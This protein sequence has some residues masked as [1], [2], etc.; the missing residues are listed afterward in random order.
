MGHLG[1]DIKLTCMVFSVRGGGNIVRILRCGILFFAIFS[2]AAAG[3]SNGPATASPK[4]TV[5]GAARTIPAIKCVDHETAAACKSF[6]QL[7]DA[8]DKRL[9]EAVWGEQGHNNKHA[10]YVCFRP[11]EDAFN[12]IEFDVPEAKEY[13]PS[14]WTLN[15]EVARYDDDSV[16]TRTEMGPMMERSKEAAE[17]GEFLDSS[18][19]Q[20]VSQ[21]TK[22]QWFQDHSKDFVYAPGLIADLRYQNGLDKG[23]VLE[24]GE[25]SMLASNRG[26]IQH[27]P[28]AW[29][30]GAYAWIER[31]N[32]QHGNVSAKDDEPEHAHI[33]VD[34]SSIYIHYKFENPSQDLVGYKMQINRLTG[35]FVEYFTFPDGN[36]EASGTCTIFR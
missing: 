31:F 29:F 28:P 1:P 6:K 5:A 4:R 15:E 9:L 22:D 11:Q 30:T 26:A 32:S 19:P 13:T 33:T 12:V 8:R 34:P 2:A 10:S 35:R 7:V 20:G 16:P 14:Q 27:D 23:P 25:W 3:Q 17:M 18:D 36:D 24:N 21:Y